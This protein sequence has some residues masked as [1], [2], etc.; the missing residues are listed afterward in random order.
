MA[1]DTCTG[2]AGLALRTGAGTITTSRA[3]AERGSADLLA[4]ALANLAHRA[5]AA[6]TDIGQIVVVNGPGSFTGVRAGLALALGLRAGAGAQPQIYPVSTF[7]ALYH[8]QATDSGPACVLTGAGRSG[9]FMQMHAAT[10]QPLEPPRL[11]RLADLSAL[12]ADHRGRVVATTQ[13]SDHPDLH[14]ALADHPHLDVRAP[15]DPLETLARAPEARALTPSPHPEPLYVRAPDA[16]RSR[17][18]FAVGAPSS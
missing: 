11:V 4:S 8:A 5:D 17:P 18:A 9:V 14:A 2:P 10:G 16:A 1:I 7:D 15:V 13:L 6:L 12:L 3:D